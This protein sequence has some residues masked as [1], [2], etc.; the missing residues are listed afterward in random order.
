MLLVLTIDLLVVGCLIFR[1]VTKGFEHTLPLAVFLLM[2]FPSGSQIALPGL[3][4]FTSQRI[5]VLTLM[6]L[7]LALQRSNNERAIPQH[8]PLAFLFM[9]E[10]LWLGVSTAHS[11]VFTIS[12]KAALSQ[13][14][15][16]FIL[17]YIFA[18]SVRSVET[19]QKSLMGFASTMIVLACFGIVEAVSGWSVVSLFPKAAHRF[20]SGYDEVDRIGRIEATFDH[21]ILFGG[22]IAL[23]IP[24]ALYLISISKS[25]IVKAF[26]WAGIVAMSFAIYKTDS[27]GPWIALIL[28]LAILVVLGGKQ[29]RRNIQIVCIL[30][31]AA[32][33][34][35]PGVWAALRYRY[36]ATA[37]PDS[38]MG[39]SYQW[40]YQL[41]DIAFS[42]LRQNPSR[43][44][45]GFGPESFY[46]LG[47]TTDFRLDGELHTVAVESCDSSVVGLMMEN[48]YVGLFLTALLLLA[49][50]IISFCSY[51]Q[52]DNSRRRLPILF[53][54]NMCAF[55]FLMTNVAI[56]GWGQQSYMLWIILAMATVY[57]TLAKT[58]DAA[59]SPAALPTEDSMS[60]F[61][62]YGPI[63]GRMT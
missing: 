14:L 5:I 54:S 38:P 21:P 13:C 45:W 6:G 33:I 40:R 15:D 24:I 37:D 1:A 4:N 27:R 12:L 18:K 32:L 9:L 30:A 62:S 59:G 42:T 36:V 35:R 23:A 31:L 25:T 57:P 58:Q 56:Y 50:A 47:L 17:F 8:L 34:A 29:V 52:L 46:Y 20:G 60:G 28:S 44:L 49:P 61:P 39:E 41:Y 2:L 11:V 53:L 63:Y 3:F 48:G 26:L 19:V 51:L 55:Y 16:Y 7:Y 10:F 43:A 22:A